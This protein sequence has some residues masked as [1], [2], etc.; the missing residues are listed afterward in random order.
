MQAGRAFEVVRCSEGE[1]LELARTESRREFP[2][3]PA[4]QTAA[5]LGRAVRRPDGWLARCYRASV[6]VLGRSRTR[7]RVPP[8]RGRGGPFFTAGWSTSVAR[9]PHVWAP[10]AAGTLWLTRPALLTS[11]RPVSRRPVSMRASVPRR[12]PRPASARAS[13]GKPIR[14]RRQTA[15]SPCSSTS[16]RRSVARVGR[17][18]SPRRKVGGE[19]A[20]GIRGRCGRCQPHSE[21]HR[22]RT[23]RKNRT[24]LCGRGGATWARLQSS[25]GPSPLPPPLPSSVLA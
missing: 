7:R 15:G 19:L 20:I 24:A 14:I 9:A 5:Q 8:A 2:P 3:I 22:H 12:R 17:R 4:G 10:D 1:E 18:T 23:A 6:P 21:P 16:A 25:S 13:V 11:R